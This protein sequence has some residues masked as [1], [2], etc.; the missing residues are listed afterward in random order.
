M[1][2]IH[3]RLVVRWSAIAASSRLG[4]ASLA[5]VVHHV[6][7][8]VA[9]LIDCGRWGRHLVHALAVCSVISSIVATVRSTLRAWSTLSTS[10]MPIV[11]WLLRLSIELVLV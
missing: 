7:D 11:V 8:R 6:W 4:H 10:S 3:H 1:A 9:I 5:V 2:A